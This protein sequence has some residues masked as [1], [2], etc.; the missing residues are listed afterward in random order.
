[1]KPVAQF[2]FVRATQKI[3][4][5]Y[6][7]SML[8]SDL[9]KITYSDVRRLASDPR[10]IERYLGIQ[11]PVNQNRV[12]EIRR[13]LESPD[14]TFPTS[15]IISVDEQCVEIENNQMT[16]YPISSSDFEK[17]P[18][19]AY[20]IARVLDGQHRL[21]GFLDDEGY[22][23]HEVPGL[24]DFELNV[25]V[26]VGA[27]LAEQA[28]IFATVN[29]AQTKVSKSLAY[30]LLEFSKARSPFKTCHMVAVTLDSFE[31]GPL[32]RR[33]KR[34]GVATPGRNNETITQATFVECLVRFIS[35]DPIEDRNRLLDG[36]TLLTTDKGS[37]SK[38]PFRQLFL[39]NKDIEIALIINNY[40]SAIRSIWRDAWDKPEIKGN[41][42]PKS[43]AFRAF[44]RYLRED[45]YPALLE[46][47]DQKVPQMEDFLPF[48]SG[49]EG[50]SNFFTR[51]QFL[52]GSAGEA[53]FLKFLRREVSL[54]ELVV[55]EKL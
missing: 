16:F 28:N 36:R 13:Y 6:A 9:A 5:F 24:S 27:D 45:V 53:R 39:D 32:Y 26:F 25:C 46:R 22:F 48:F 33:I 15:I 42:I 50:D 14:A 34:L 3:G 17:R 35:S 7:G 44:M 2:Q 8:A 19:E 11:R 31:D 23:R 20:E 10:D 41:I 47:T 4:T 21:A 51:E 49:I 30:D 37:S 29:L 40:F 18:V 55:P 38:A 54:S 1:M 43:N 12:N 52:P